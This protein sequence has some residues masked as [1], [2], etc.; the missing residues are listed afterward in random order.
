MQ[1]PPPKSA[2]EALTASM[3]PTLSAK[4]D[5]SRL[6]TSPRSLRQLCHELHDV[7][8]LS[9]GTVTPINEVKQHSQLRTSRDVALKQ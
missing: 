7:A 6:A 9:D 5:V 2:T 3:L 1:L 8:V 4:L